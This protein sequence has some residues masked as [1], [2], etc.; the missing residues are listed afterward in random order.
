MLYAPEIHLC[1]RNPSLPCPKKIPI[2]NYLSSKDTYI[3]TLLPPIYSSLA[4]NAM[5]ISRD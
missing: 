2:Y 5:D 3:Y 1:V 4:H